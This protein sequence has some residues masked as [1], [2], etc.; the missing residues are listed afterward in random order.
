MT[1]ARACE[2]LVQSRI[3]Q[4]TAWGSNSGP[5]HREFRAK[6]TVSPSHTLLPLQLFLTHQERQRLTFADHSDRE[7]FLKA[8]KLAAVSVALV[9]DAVVTRQ[10]HVL[11]AFL[12]RPLSA[13][14]VTAKRTT[15]RTII[16]VLIVM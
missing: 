1:E 10:T 15:M 3:Q 2:R 4:H 5:V 9:N 6:T 16:I 8:T 11:G 12:H 7:T 13:S 14:S